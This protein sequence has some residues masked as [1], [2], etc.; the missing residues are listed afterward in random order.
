MKINHTSWKS[1]A[2]AVT[3]SLLMSGVALA[4]TISISGHVF[5]CNNAALPGVPGV[6]MTLSPGAISNISAVI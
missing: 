3:V 1:V 4:G 6:A 2:L 5:Y